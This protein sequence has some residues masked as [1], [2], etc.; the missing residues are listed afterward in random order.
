MEQNHSRIKRWRDIGIIDCDVHNHVPPLKSLYPYLSAYWRD[1]IEDRQIPGIESNFYPK[2][3]DLSVRPEFNPS[4]GEDTDSDLA[5][6]R[7]QI[8]DRLNVRYAVLNCITGVQLFHNEDF[9]IALASALNDWQMAEWVEKDKRLKASIIVADQNIHYAVKEIERLG[10]H[11]DF[12]QVLL[13]ARSQMP[14]GKRHYWPIYEA[15]ERYGLPICIHAGGTTHN[16]ITAV[17][18][19]SYYIEEYVNISASFQEQVISLVSEGVFSKFPS[20]KFVLAESGFTW[21]PSLMWR[22]DKN[23]KG[24]RRDIPW[25]D[26]LPSEIIREHFRVTV[27]PFD[28]P[29]NAKHLIDILEQVGSDEMLLFSSD[30]PHWHYDS[31]EAVVPDAFPTDLEQRVFAQNALKVYTKLS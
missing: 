25:V 31:L 21:L 23:W 27:Q 12:V 9:A 15:A 4:F 3:V 5:Q 29:S 2:G 24:L 17:G 1:Y 19:P 20:L 16:P 28:E 6:M 10:E 26:R 14:Y 18:W 8:L 7:V 11:P 22:F 13:L 30:F